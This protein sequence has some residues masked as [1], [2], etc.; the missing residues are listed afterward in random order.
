MKDFLKTLAAVILGTGLVIFGGVSLLIGSL[1]SM[2]TMGIG[3]AVTSVAP[4]SILRIDFEKGVSVQDSDLPIPGFLPAELGMPATGEGFYKMVRAIENAATDP[5]IKM[6]YLYPQYLNAQ[7]THIEEIRNA[8]LLFRQSGKPVICY[9]DTYSQQAYYMASAS[10]KVI[11]NPAGDISL[12]GF[13]LNV[14]YF[15]DLFDAYGI[16]AQ[17][18][19]HGSYKSGGEIYTSPEMS[20]EERTQMASYLNSAWSHW[21]S[22]IERSRTLP[23][24]T[25]DSICSAGFR[26]T[27]QEALDLHLIDEIWHKDELTEY[28]CSMNDVSEEKKL[29]VISLSDYAQIFPAGKKFKREKIAVVYASGDLRT[30][31][32][33]DGVSSGNFASQLRQYRTDSTVKAVVLRIESPGGDPLAADVITRELELIAGVKPLVVSMGDMA[34]SGGYWIAAPAHAI[35]ANPTSLTGSIGVYSIFFNGEKTLNEVLHIRNERINTHAYSHFP[36]YRSRL[37]PVETGLMEKMVDSTYNRFIS[38]VS[39]GRHLERAQV[40][41]V[42]KGR[43]WSGIQA[44]ENKMVDN[45]GGLSDAVRAASLMANILD[46]RIVEYPA[47]ERFLD[48]IISLGKKSGTSI[49]DYLHECILTLTKNQGIQV[50][51]PYIYNGLSF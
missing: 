36:S 24:G 29:P 6:I 31:T 46:Y 34:A 10:D 45:L 8:L 33:R 16:E 2:V 20:P 48:K 28:M 14:F 32:G 51:I 39:Q 19:R 7:M 43:V 49:P 23:E 25:L 27:P 12:Q 30:G 4:N 1:T 18:I 47:P 35:F 40:E 38:I 11:V 22:G 21:S 15:K 26:V 5:N 3:P 50:R 42:A 13:S 37:S 17:V 41:E 9:S 44:L